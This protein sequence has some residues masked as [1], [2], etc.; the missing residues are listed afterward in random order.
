MR[1]PRAARDCGLNPPHPTA[2]VG[3]GGRP[4]DCDCSAL[5]RSSHPAALG[6]AG[7]ADADGAAV[8]LSRLARDWDPGR[9]QRHD[10]PHRG[11]AEA[12]AAD[13]QPPNHRALQASG[14]WG[15]PLL[16]GRTRTTPSPLLPSAPFPWTVF[17]TFPCSQ[18]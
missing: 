14:P 18:T 17:F 9:G 10:R 5:R 8:P 12:A 11:R 3:L 16:V 2:Q 1:T 15:A 13:R 4:G 7:G 6:P